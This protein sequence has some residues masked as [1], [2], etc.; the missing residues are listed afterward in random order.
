MVVT[1]TLFCLAVA[2]ANATSLDGNVLFEHC[3]DYDLSKSNWFGGA[4]AGYVLGARDTFDQT[5]KSRFACPKAHMAIS[6]SSR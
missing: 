5:T 6:R 2:E 4:C 3:K 1:L